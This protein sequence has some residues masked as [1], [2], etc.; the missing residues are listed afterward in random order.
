MASISEIPEVRPFSSSASLLPIP[1]PIPSVAFLTSAFY[2]QNLRGNAI[3]PIENQPSMICLGP[4]G[5][6]DPTSMINLETN[7]IPLK[8]SDMNLDWSQAFR[9]WPSVTPGCINWFRR[10][11]N[12]QRTNWEEY[13]IS[14]CLNLSLSEMIRSEPMLISAS[15]FW[16]DALNAFMF[17]HG[18]MTPTLMDVVIL[19]GL[20]IHVADRPFRLLEKASFKIETKSIGG[21]KGYIGKNMKTGSVSVREHTAF[22][23]MWLEKFIFCGKAVG[24]TNN[25][26]K[27][28]ENLATGNPVPLGKHLLGSV[29]HLL[30]Q[31]SSR[32]RKNQPIT[33]LGGPW[34][35]IQLWL[36]MY[37]CTKLWQ[38]NCQ[39]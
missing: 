16:S 9:S 4:M 31:I 17:N 23:N 25:N 32:L 38:S 3:I 29:Y 35:F 24:P 37:I 7:R 21:W 11:A 5:N 14:Q 26:L 10:I 6:P 34:W 39:R 2:F 19:T 30:H 20:N 36:H 33:N 13:G 27:L 12:V 15:Y 18:P 8:S 1:F 28:A 22:L